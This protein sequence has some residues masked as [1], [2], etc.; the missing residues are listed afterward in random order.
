MR[1]DETALGVFVITP[2][3]FTEDGALDEASTD[4][5]TEAYLAAGASGLTI[6]GIMGEAPKLD[7]EEQQRFVARVLHRVAGRVPVVVG[8]SAPGLASMRA[9]AGAAMGAGAAGVMI[10]P[11]PGLR[12]DDA[13]VAYMAQAA[14]A[15]G[16]APYV[17]QDYPQ[18]N[19][20]HISPEMI[21]RMAEDPRLVM[22]KAEDWPGLDKL[23]AIR[24]L[25]A[26]GRM[27]RIAILGGNG[28]L[29][30]PQELER[31]ADGI[32]TGY[33]V[34]EMLVRVQRM[35]AGGERAAAHD[36]FDL[37]LPLIRYEHQP[38]LGLAVRKYVLARRGIIGSATLR[39]PGPKLTPETRAEVDWL[40]ERLS[41][42][43][44]VLA[45]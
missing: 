31:G 12:G 6:L 37:H 14:E 36:L 26:E 44:P 10:A 9:L 22:L 45:L 2:T 25:S 35:L 39:A 7:A 18:S 43:D 34:P 32:M 16:D 41:R 20:I 40:L 19:G 15:V 5:M 17:L 24:R 13:V 38:G 3:P 21:R 29:F 27:R 11:T 8:V 30:L 33:A 4:R 23:S 42:R 28:G 1:L